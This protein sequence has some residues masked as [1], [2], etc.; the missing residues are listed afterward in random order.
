MLSQN[1]DIIKQLHF[2]FNSLV[3]NGSRNVL[4]FPKYGSCQITWG[5]H[6]IDR[7]YSMPFQF[8]PSQHLIR[9]LQDTICLLPYRN[10]W[11]VHLFPQDFPVTM[12]RQRS[13]VDSANGHE[14][15]YRAIELSSGIWGLIKKPYLDH[16]E[17]N[18][19][20]S[21][22]IHSMILKTSHNL[23]SM[24]SPLHLLD[25]NIHSKKVTMDK[26]HNLV[27]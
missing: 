19:C 21:R 17:N 9:T 24:L 7:S 16:L 20:H 22:D 10:N 26:T 8:L 1:R 23:N 12:F 14:E 6:G 4:A 2:L 13:H 18:L 15:S 11:S 27:L 5:F 25:N 3:A